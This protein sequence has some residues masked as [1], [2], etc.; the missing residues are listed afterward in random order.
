MSEFIIEL[1]KRKI[2]F[3]FDGKNIILGEYDTG[4]H[5]R[6]TLI[7]KNK[8]LLNRYKLYIV[9]Y[10]GL[11]NEDG[12]LYEDGSIRSSIAKEFYK[13]ITNNKEYIKDIFCDNE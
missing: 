3:K 1:Y 7:F 6:T 5:R 13:W 8:I 9:K 10:G 4:F 2:P 11:K 12:C